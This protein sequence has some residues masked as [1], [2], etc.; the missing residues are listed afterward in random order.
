MIMKKDMIALACVNL[1][2]ILGA[3]PKLCELDEEAAALIHDEHISIGFA[4]KG[5]PWGTLIFEDGK[6]HMERGLVKPKILLPFSTPEKFN[7]MID[8]TVTP[9][10]RKGFLHIGFL[11]KKFMKLT[12]ILTAYLRADKEAL[13]DEEFFRKST[14]LMLYVIA[15][16]VAELGNFDPVS[17][18]SAS[19]ITDGVIRIAIDNGPAAT[20]TAK[21]H[22]LR[23]IPE[24]CETYT[25]Y[26]RFADIRTARALFD[27]EINAVACIGTGEV[28]V[29][30]MISQ[31]DNVNRILDRVA[32]YLA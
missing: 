26:M 12:D 10:P 11:L 28:R 18:A 8:G 25:S 16:A 20:I 9:I 24:D 3:L 30:G 29:G 1:Y 19:Y 21:D 2:A 5:G 32:M 15:G 4:V 7:G 27:G 17:R 14:T 6:C 22:I 23:S 13:K 31:V